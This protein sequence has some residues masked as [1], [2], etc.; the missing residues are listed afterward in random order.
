M[1][2]TR[3]QGRSRRRW[4][5]LAPENGRVALPV[6]WLRHAG[7]A[8]LAQ[9]DGDRLLDRFLLCRRMAGANRSILLPIIYQ[10][11]DVAADRRLAASLFEWHG[12]P[13]LCAESIECDQMRH[14]H[15]IEIRPVSLVPYALR[16]FDI[17]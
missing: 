8:S 16:L 12:I 10:R 14:G 13:P 6:A 1:S 7:L 2:R 17:L 5:A 9:C 11:L 4:P 15:R 3:G